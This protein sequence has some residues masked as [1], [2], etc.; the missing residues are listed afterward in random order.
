M[1]QGQQLFELV[2]GKLQHLQRLVLVEADAT[3]QNLLAS[4]AQYIYG[5]LRHRN[6]LLWIVWPAEP[7]IEHVGRADN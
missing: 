7:T 5:C 3:L 4:Y 2:V 1:R 6:V